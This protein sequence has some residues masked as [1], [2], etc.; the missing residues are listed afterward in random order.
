M[1]MAQNKANLRSGKAEIA[2]DVQMV[3]VVAWGLQTDYW[4]RTK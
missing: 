4:Q 2:I 3:Y 1:G